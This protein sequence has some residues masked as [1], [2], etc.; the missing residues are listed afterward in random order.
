MG[1][2]VIEEYGRSGTSAD[3][4]VQVVRLSKLLATTKDATTSSTAESI[5]LNRGTT[6]LRVYPAEDHRL[7]LGT[8]T[9]STLYA[10]AIAGQA[11]DIGVEQGVANVLYYEL[12]A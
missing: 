12:D 11:M 4:E 10:T 1:T 5:T 7:C 9:T 8:D 2:I 3:N 6:L